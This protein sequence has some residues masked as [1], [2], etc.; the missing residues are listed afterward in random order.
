MYTDDQAFVTALDQKIKF[1]GVPAIG[2]HMKLLKKQLMSG[3]ENIAHH[4][5]T[6]KIS[7]TWLHLY[8]EFIPMRK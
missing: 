5:N 7:I 2:T 3:Y 4:L 1:E 8:N 6:N